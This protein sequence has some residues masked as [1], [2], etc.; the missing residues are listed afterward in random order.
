MRGW[1][2]SLFVGL[3]SGFSL[4]YICAFSLGYTAAITMPHWYADLAKALS[5]QWIFMIAWEA[6]VVQLFGGSLPC[7]ILCF[8]LFKILPLN[9]TAFAIAFLLTYLFF[10]Y[11]FNISALEFQHYNYE[12]TL[13]FFMHPIA[14]VLGL[15]AALFFA[16][17]QL[18]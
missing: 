13:W 10:T 1:G 15:A 2:A 8:C 16:K 17:R 18:K 7:F 3:L 11:V 9:K 5:S 12:L 4:A 6:I 14:I